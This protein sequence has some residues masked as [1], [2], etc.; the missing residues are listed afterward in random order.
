MAGLSTCLWSGPRK[1]PDAP[2]ITDTLNGNDYFLTEN[3]NDFITGGR[4]ERLEKL[5][6]VKIR[7][8]AEFLDEVQASGASVD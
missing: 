8:L 1:R 2:S 6:G 4:R 5:L 3:V 7:R